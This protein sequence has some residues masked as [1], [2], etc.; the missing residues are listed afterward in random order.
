[1]IDTVIF[2][3]GPHKTGTTSFQKFLDLNQEEFRLV[4]I[5]IYR[6]LFRRGC[7]ANDIGVSVLRRGVIDDLYEGPWTGAPEEINQEINKA[8]WRRQIQDHLKKIVQNS[9]CSQLLV[10]SEHLSFVREPGEIERLLD[11]FPDQ[12]KKWRV[13][14]VNRDDKARW[15][16]YSAQIKRSG[17]LEQQKISRERNSWAYLQQNEWMRD[18]SRIREVW[19]EVAPVEVVEYQRNTIPLLLDTL[20]VHPSSNP[21]IFE[22]TTPSASRVKGLYNRFFATTIVGRTWRYLKILRKRAMK[23]S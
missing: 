11:L 18:F 9:A 22:N 16:S 12:I 10:S 23:Q 2:H 6:P 3:I 17:I 8:E 21:F 14:Y 15:N 19:G 1:M 13:I 7:A 5:E 4:G 20:G